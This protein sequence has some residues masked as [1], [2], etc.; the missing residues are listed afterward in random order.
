MSDGSIKTDFSDEVL[1]AF[2]NETGRDW[3]GQL[4]VTCDACKTDCL[5]PLLSEHR[6][7]MKKGK[8]RFCFNC[9]SK[10]RLGKRLDDG[11]REILIN[12]LLW[13]QMAISGEII[14]QNT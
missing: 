7:A 2:A 10:L 11:D 1:I 12:D 5:E 3:V 14:N 13:A 4:N 8:D 6:K 9:G